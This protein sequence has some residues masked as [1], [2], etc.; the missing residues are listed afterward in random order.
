M[1]NQQRWTTYSTIMGAII[2]R[3]RADEGWSQENLARRV[4]I[5]VATLSRIE[6]GAASITLEQLAIVA[7][8]FD[9]PPAKLVRE[10]D[11]QSRELQRH[12]YSVFLRS[13]EAGKVETALKLAGAAAIG[14]LVASLLAKDSVEE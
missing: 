3:Y 10:A 1:T 11:F 4:G 2:A 7:A 8:A 12:G 9:E 14:G 13:A 5:G 6:R